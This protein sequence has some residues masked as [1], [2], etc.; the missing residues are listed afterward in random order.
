M[1]IYPEVNGKPQVVIHVD[2]VADP[3]AAEDALVK[4]DI[5]MS[6][7]LKLATAHRKLVEV[8]NTYKTAPTYEEVEGVKQYVGPVSMPMP[9][10]EYSDDPEDLSVPEADFANHL[11]GRIVEGVP[12]SMGGPAM[13]AENYLS[14]AMNP[15]VDIPG[16][17]EEESGSN[18]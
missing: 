10:A 18:S 16:S 7:N 13:T 6:K 3:I 12:G 1:S 14:T 15:G 4:N 5:R 17:D 8:T 11:I 9:I 2:S